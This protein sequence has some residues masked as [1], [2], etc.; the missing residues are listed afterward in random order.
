MS[1]KSLEICYDIAQVPE[2]DAAGNPA[3]AA[4]AFRNAAMDLI[5]TA[6]N[7]AGLGEWAGAEIGEDD[8][9]FGF[10]VD[11]FDAAE[12]AVRAAVVGT[13]F[14]TIREIIR[15]EDE[16]EDEEDE[17]DGAEED[18]DA[19]EEDAEDDSDDA[20]EDDADEDDEMDEDDEVDEAE[21]E[22]A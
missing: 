11:D 19:F 17:E 5:E 4:L 18:A 2:T 10:E 21:V 8:L 13:P 3:E 7:E 15:F 6:L 22:K 14:E 1:Y 12:A 20:D 16:D 9:T